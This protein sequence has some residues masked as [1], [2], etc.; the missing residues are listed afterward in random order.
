VEFAIRLPGKDDE[1]TYLPIDSK[2]PQEDYERLQ[3]AQEQ[4]DK[5]MIEESGKALEREIKNQAKTINEKYIKPPL[6]TN[7]A[8]MYLPTEGLFAEVVRRPGLLQT[9]QRDYRVTVMGPTTLAAFLTALQMGFSTLRI[10]KNSNEVWKVL[11]GI[12]NEFNKYG[13]VW[14]KLEKQLGTAQKT[15]KEVGVKSRSVERALNQVETSSTAELPDFSQILS[16]SVLDEEI[17]D[18]EQEDEAE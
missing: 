1:I 14:E 2:F 10:S 4:A 18:L 6:S 5:E 13:K 8:I 16:N 17:A 11:G 3:A 7:F 12:K 15:V 9:L